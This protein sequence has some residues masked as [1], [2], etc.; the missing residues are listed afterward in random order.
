N[1]LHPIEL[2]AHALLNGP[3]EN[4]HE[5]FELLT[6]SQYILLT[7]LK[8]IENRLTSFEKAFC[9]EGLFVSDRDVQNSFSRIKELRKLLLKSLKTLSKISDRVNDMSTKLE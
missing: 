4:L 9:E 6:Q 2:T 7:R 8:L 1:D 5:N 3:L